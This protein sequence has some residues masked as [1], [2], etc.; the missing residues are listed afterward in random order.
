MNLVGK[1]VE[2]LFSNALANN[3][4][5]NK[6]Y[7]SRN[8]QPYRFR[9]VG[10]K[11]DWQLESPD[12]LD[13][14][15]FRDKSLKG[16]KNKVSEALGD[17]YGHR[18]ATEVLGYETKLDPDSKNRSFRQGFDSVYYDRET[19]QTVIGEFKGQDSQESQKQKRIRWT[20][21]VCEKMINRQGVY[22]RATQDERDLAFDIKREFDRGL[23]RYEV[24]RTKF[25]EKASNIY[26]VV[27]KRK[28]SDYE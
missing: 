28:Y 18:F 24:I 5:E 1:S 9:K 21:D 25:D 13:Y 6:N 22:A 7:E 8:D 17:S 19:G 14:S 16:D 3:K 20:P 4:L 27:E 10:E 26:T 2:Q 15:K 23:V 11:Y 12:G